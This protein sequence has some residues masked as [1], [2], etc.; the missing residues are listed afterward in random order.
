MDPEDGFFL[1]KPLGQG[2]SHHALIVSSCMLD[3][4]PVP[5]QST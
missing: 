4:T 3:R 5:D 2:R 1:S